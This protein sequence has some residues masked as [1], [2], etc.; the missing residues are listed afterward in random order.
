MA[1]FVGLLDCVPYPLPLLS[2]LCRTIYDKTVQHIYA[3]NTE[4]DWAVVVPADVLLLF[5]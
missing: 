5:P 2:F 1:A 4:D 3:V